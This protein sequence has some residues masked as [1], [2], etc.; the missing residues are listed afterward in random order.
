MG[1]HR[2]C[3]RRGVPKRCQPEQP[4]VVSKQRLIAFYENKTP[5]ILKRY[6]P[7]PRVHYHT[8]LVDEPLSS[9][10]SREGL[11][12]ELIAAQERTLQHAA[13]VWNARLW[14]SGDVLDVGC[15]LGGGAVFW[16]QEFGAL[17]TAVTI[18]ASHIEL[19]GRFAAQAGVGSQVKTLLCDALEVPGE[20]RFDAV[21]A[22]YSS[23]S[24]PRRPWFQRLERLLRAEGHIFIFD[25]FLVSSEYEEPFNRHWCSQIGTVE[26]YITTAREAGFK[27][28]LIE[29]VSLRAIHF[30]TRT[31]ALIRMEAQDERL[32]PSERAKLDES[33]RT[34]S[35][36]RQGLID[37]GLCDLLMVL[38]RH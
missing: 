24:F 15:G 2:D 22:I 35:L 4:T 32:G 29:D 18:A 10:A 8:G 12:A 5:Q 36:V 14:L 26:E 9:R 27:V 34:H 30:W 19:V 7:G 23:N 13:E 31:V 25:T 37:R 33:S 21:V 28:T 3:L 16:A 20:N 38:T 6:G 1:G 17:V 11:R